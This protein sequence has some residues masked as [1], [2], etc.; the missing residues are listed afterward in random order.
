MSGTYSG[1]YCQFQGGLN[2]LWSK[3]EVFS[4][5]VTC[6][7]KIGSFRLAR[8]IAPCSKPSVSAWMFCVMLKNVSVSMDVMCHAQN[9]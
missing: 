7:G 4:M 6:C 3:T 2:V 5:D 9:C 1:Q 8:Q